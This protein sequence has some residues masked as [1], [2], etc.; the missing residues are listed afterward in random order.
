M[1]F[2]L[3]TLCS[4]III[5]SRNTRS[6][7][8]NNETLEHKRSR[9]AKYCKRCS[10]PFSHCSLSNSHSIILNPLCKGGNSVHRLYQNSRNYRFQCLWFLQKSC[11][12]ERLDFLI[13]KFFQKFL[14][15]KLPDYRKFALKPFSPWSV[16][17]GILFCLGQY[18]FYH[19]H[20]YQM[21]S[22][23][24]PTNIAYQQSGCKVFRDKLTPSVYYLLHYNKLETPKNT[25][26]QRHISQNFNLMRRKEISK[27]FITTRF[28]FLFLQNQ[29]STNLPPLYA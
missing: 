4:L 19:F 7:L 24:G 23:E 12:L 1:C 25:N 2:H 14:K 22:Q 10:L 5:C 3:C 8:L 17:W 20:W 16:R 21:W 26:F 29:L 11:N 13:I 6:C 28:Q 15:K 27:T 18:R 9:T